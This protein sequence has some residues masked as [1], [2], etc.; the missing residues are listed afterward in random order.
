[1][2]RKLRPFSKTKLKVLD[3]DM[4]SDHSYSITLSNNKTEKQAIDYLLSTN[5]E[6]LLPTKEGRKRI[7]EIL[8]LDKKYSRAFDLFMLP[9]HVNTESSVVFDDL[10]NITLIEL[11]T[12]MKYLPNNPKGFFFGATQNEFDLA[13]LLGNKY[14]FCF[15]SLH[16]NSLSFSLLSLSELEE[17]IITKRLQHQINL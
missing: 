3:E 7:M 13:T 2:I 10:S 11:K 4:A 5:K 1:V 15:V 8:Q 12:T 6:F 14:K 9:G 17:R 16:E